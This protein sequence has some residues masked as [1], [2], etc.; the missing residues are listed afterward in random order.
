MCMHVSCVQYGLWLQAER[1]A[2]NWG[3]SVFCETPEGRVE[4]HRD[5][6]PCHQKLS[7]STSLLVNLR[8][9][10]SLQRCMSV[11]KKYAHVG[12]LVGILVK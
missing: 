2:S 1:P 5:R 12:L 11:L 9:L 3:P 6:E 10:E 7:D 4:R 8:P